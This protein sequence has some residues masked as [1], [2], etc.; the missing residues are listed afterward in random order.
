MMPDSISPTS[1]FLAWWK[2]ENGHAYKMRVCDRL[3]SA[4]AGVK[5]NCPVCNISNWTDYA[6]AGTTPIVGDVEASMEK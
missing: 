6:E 4:Q 2:C 5:N 3:A 1:T